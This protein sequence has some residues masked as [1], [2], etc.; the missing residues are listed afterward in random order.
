MLRP[1]G[2]DQPGAHPERYRR[3]VTLVE[4]LVVVF[5]VFVA[6]MGFLFSLPRMRE[7]ARMAG[8]QRN[9][10]QVGI[11]LALYDR[12]EG[13]LP[14]VPKLGSGPYANPGTLK[15]LIDSLAVPDLSELSDPAPSLER[16]KSVSSGER[17]IPGFLCP[18]EVSTAEVAGFPAPVSYRSTGG[19]AP[20]GTNGGFA[21][22]RKLRLAEVEEGDGLGYTAAFSERRLGS[23][24]ESNPRPDRYR[25]ANGTVGDEG[26]SD[27]T[28]GI[29]KDDAGYSW[30]EASWR[31]TLYNHVF[32]PNSF[33]DCVSAD[34]VTAAMGASSAHA[35]GVNVLMFDGSV[36]TISPTM[37]L[38]L[39]KALGTTH[40]PPTTPA[41]FPPETLQEP[42]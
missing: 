7:R 19:D 20:S 5:I 8:C 2:H 11:A 29:W 3:G 28:A 13:S 1:R 12:A 16:R 15:A 42:R 31:S 21:P 36:R 4:V 37:S 18:S 26:C 9:L 39:W 23:G 22:G 10:G 25:S 38:P 24:Q 40:S 14:T 30:V 35:S 34:G 33:A 17:R 6:L 41:V 27:T 32:A